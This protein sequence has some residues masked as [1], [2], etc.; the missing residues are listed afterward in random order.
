MSSIFKKIINNEISSYKI[1]ED[2]KYLAFLD[3]F[4]LTYG[5]VLVI[6]KKETNYIFDI[7]SDEYI[8]LWNFAK[9][10]AK[11]M[12]KA[13]VC[14]RIGVAVLGLEVP[15]AHIHLVPING[16]SDINFDKPKKVFSPE[17]MREVADKIRQSLS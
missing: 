17:K 5:H 16:V 4:P 11:A 2:D 14:E 7:D 13:L 12:D 9:Q 1:F 10:V 8:G 15:H 6:P 3:A